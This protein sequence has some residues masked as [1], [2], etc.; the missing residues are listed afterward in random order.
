VKAINEL[1]RANSAKAIELLQAAIPYDGGSFFGV[2]YTRGRAYLQAGRGDKALEEFQ[3]ILAL[4]NWLFSPYT[5]PRMSLPELGLARAYAL[6][7]DK[8]KSRMAYEDFFALW[9][10]AD[11]DIPS[12]KQAKAE[13]AKL[14]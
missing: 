13:Y 6:Q 14:Q 7:G 5:S 8:A 11:P 4:R 9:K 12:L 3:K 1:N 10:D 2:R